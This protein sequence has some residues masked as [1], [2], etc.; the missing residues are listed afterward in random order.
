LYLEE[1][2]PIPPHDTH[3]ETFKGKPEWQQNDP[4]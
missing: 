1:Q 4:R 3:K 2:L